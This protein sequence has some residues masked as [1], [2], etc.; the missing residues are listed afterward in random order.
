MKN[1]DVIL[2]NPK[3]FSLYE[4]KFP[5][6]AALFLSYSLKKAGCSVKIFDTQ[7]EPDENFYKLIQLQKP[8]WVGFSVMTGST[9]THA[10]R[11]SRIIK[12]LSPST[13]VVWGG[14]HPSLLPEDTL[15]H[16]LID[17]V[18][19]REGERT[20]VE[21]TKVLKENTDLANVKGIGYKKNDKIILNAQ[22]EFI[23]NWDEEVGLDW[24]SVDIKNYINRFGKQI[25]IPLITSRGCPFRCRFCW[26]L[27]ANNRQWRSWSAERTIT[28]I[29]RLLA[30]GIN[31]ITF[32]DDNFGVNMERVSKITDFL[33]K[34]NMIWSFEGFRV[35]LRLTPE[36]MKNLKA[37]GCHHI[38]FG[39]ECG[40][41]KML[42]YI[43]KDITVEQLLESAKLTGEHKI[44]AKYSWVV[45]FPKEIQEDRLKMMDLI[46]KLTKLNPNCAHYIG[47]FSPYPGSELYQETIEAGWKPPRR[48]EEWAL[49]REEY[50]LPYIK[51]MWYLRSISLTC[52]FKFAMDSPIRPFSKSKKLYQLPVKL[53]KLTAN[54]RWKHR[55]F[56]FPIEY[57]LL[58]IGR[59]IQ[60]KVSLFLAKKTRKLK[61][62]FL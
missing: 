45:G 38:C 53:L 42:D 1:Y 47:I 54:L 24:D 12:K 33:K 50:D 29:K 13:K 7:V 3:F 6:F 40:T 58:T 44:G 10:L 36:L 41:Q 28:E 55:F 61:I 17:I 52:F 51:N 9:I 5:P 59:N 14:P 30:Y 48:I 31:Y 43:K 60:D 26:N 19:I 18:I 39:A 49:F 32:E 21:L 57:K 27:K 23:T 46:D 16:K 37:A 35:G 8:L 25:H 22:R 15:K 2:V 56:S 4:V 62:N 20:V 11:L 34:Q